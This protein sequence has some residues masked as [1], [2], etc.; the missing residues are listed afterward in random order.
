VTDSARSELPFPQAATDFNRKFP[1]F[2]AIVTGGPAA[3]PATGRQISPLVIK[4]SSSRQMLVM[5]L[6]L[7]QHFPSRFPGDSPSRRRSRYASPTASKIARV[8]AAGTGDV[9]VRFA[10]IG[11]FRKFAAI[12]TAGAAATPSTGRQISPLI[13][14][15]S[16]SRQ[17]L[18][19]Q[20]HLQQHFP[21]RL[22]GDS[23][24][25]R[26]SRYAFPNA[27]Q[28]ARV[29]AAGT[30]DAGVRFAAIGLFRKFAA[31]VTGGAAATPSTGRQTSSLVVKSSSSR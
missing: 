8:C 1:T 25:R 5:Q 28:I 15:S 20:R 10:A 4:S 31:I 18:V 12:V 21:S 19:M 16:S 27:S 14:K 9:R 22:P 13:I 29:S 23:P 11:S 24:S 6:H 7:Q 2:A 17:M 30:G 26:R 3:T